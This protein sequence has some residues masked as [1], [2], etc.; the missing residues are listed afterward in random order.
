MSKN[1]SLVKK[2][3]NPFVV[4][5]IILACIVVVSVGAGLIFKALKTG[6]VRSLTV[7]ATYAEL[8]VGSTSSS[9]D[10]DVSIFPTTA[11]NKGV[12]VYS[13]NT[14]VAT[15]EIVNGKVRVTGV[16]EGSA[17]ITVQ[18][19]SRRSVMD[20]F[21]VSVKDVVIDELW[22]VDE[23]GEEIS[24]I[25]VQK[26]GMNH[27]I[28]FKV[29][30][31]N[32]NL[33]KLKVPESAK[34][35]AIV[36]AYIDTAKQCLVIK[37]NP[38]SA[39]S[40]T[41]VDVDIYQT[42]SIS[43]VRSQYKSLQVDLIP[44]KTY[45]RF[46][47]STPSQPEARK[48]EH[49]NFIYLDNK[50]DASRANI[51]PQI[52]YDADFN[53]TYE[54]SV[55]DYDIFV[56]GTKI[57][58]N[59]GVYVKSEGG[60]NKFRIIKND[61]YFTVQTFSAF[62]LGDS[63]L[64]K[65]AHKF[66]DAENQLEIIYRNPVSSDGGD[67]FKLI[68]GAT[69]EKGKTIAL[70]FSYD[71]GVSAKFVTINFNAL[72][73]TRGEIV[74]EAKILPNG[75]MICIE[76]GVEVV[77]I[78]KENNRV[79][80][81]ALNSGNISVEFTARFS[82]WDERYNAY[83]T[84]QSAV[85]T[86]TTNFTVKSEL[87]DLFASINGEEV[88]T[89]TISYATLASTT[90]NQKYLQLNIYPLPFEDGV[91][92]YSKLRFKVTYPSSYTDGIV[93]VVQSNKVGDFTSMDDSSYTIFITGPCNDVCLEFYYDDDRSGTLSEGEKVVRVFLTIGA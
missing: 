6:S 68:S 20:S 89:K 51:K 14:E 81:K 83:Q 77:E 4:V 78:Y 52:G 72:E 49:E 87:S 80:V 24:Q 61:G 92:D 74:Y 29:L 3:K 34:N 9:V 60:V 62:G 75:H 79:F 40:S 28:P 54:T 1:K 16:G 63:S 86:I 90:D 11:S 59:E 53:S 73:F 25:T 71:K 21:D 45:L 38:D 31:E 12:Y 66:T 23:N 70:E 91:L 19:A 22:F 67:E 10:V 42:S 5:G 50:G 82:Y 76:N 47:F 46:G 64:I 18:S 8:S 37:T 33:N 39:L 84:G 58:F 85:A 30:P 65:F 57:A 36:D 17:K 26:D 35:G 7:E 48:Y 32:G 15:V 2:K 41:N 88:K 44:R 69:L 93:R 55:D 27:E 13:S 56:D 43:E